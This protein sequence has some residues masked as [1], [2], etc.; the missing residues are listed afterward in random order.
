MGACL[1][2][3][4]RT[5]GAAA[6]VLLAVTLAAIWMLTEQTPDETSALSAGAARVVT[7]APDAL[8]GG[9]SGVAGGD[10]VSLPV[11]GGAGTATDGGEAASS[12]DDGEASS[13][14]GGGASSPDDGVGASALGVDGSASSDSKNVK[15]RSG[16][17]SGR[18]GGTDAPLAGLMTLV[19]RVSA[20]TA[21]NIRR[22]AH[23]VEFL[24][25]G[26]FASVA[27]TCL[28]KDGRGLRWLA[29]HVL[30]FC[31]ACSLVDQTHKLFVPGRHFDCVDLVFDA[32]GYVVGIALALGVAAL[33]RQIGS[34]RIERAKSSW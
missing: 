2:T 17:A 25:V 12:S 1:R 7:A 26:F 4:R 18:A 8:V 30:L 29:L 9:D 10:D 20:W 32:A 34:R 31:V 3:V 5:A 11:I 13:V 27:A 24:L 22:V 16:T 19:L 33:V 21:T 14:P 23:T 15:A 6:L 28:V